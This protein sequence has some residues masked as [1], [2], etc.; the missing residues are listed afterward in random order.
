MSSIEKQGWHWPRFEQ[1]LCGTMTDRERLGLPDHYLPSRFEDAIA[2]V[3]RML[4]GKDRQ[5][6][7]E[8]VENTEVPLVERLV[9][10]NFLAMLGD[11][12]I[13]PTHPEM[14][15]IPG[16]DVHI[17]LDES[18]VESVMREFH[19]LGL[20]AQWILKECP[21]HMVKLKD[22]RMA[23]YP[24]TNQEYRDFLLDT[25]YPEL[26]SSWAC[27]RYPTERSNHPVFTLSAAAADAYAGWLSEKTER[28]FRLPSE[29]EWEFAA[30]GPDGLE[31]PWGKD[32]EPDYA[33]TVETGIF[34]TSPVG[35]FKEGYSPFGLAD[36]AGNVEEYVLDH[37][38]LYSGGHFIRDHLVQLN[39]EYRV[40]RGGCF[41]RLRDLAR[42]RRRH[43]RNPASSMYA[44][45]F[46]LAEDI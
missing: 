37:Y 25:Q 14:I 45:G 13:N 20:D 5:A 8:M 24:V 40:A 35:I 36:M 10:G 43:G 26:P 4:Y 17:G 11:P 31:F 39:G 27:R 16:G 21:R 42:T 7:V 9:A 6:Y 1:V 12:R 23:K 19:S 18:D 2:D 33:N 15:T 3:Y 41:S 46:R 44:M 32:Y 22:Y 28:H 38:D 29:A 30:A 34:S